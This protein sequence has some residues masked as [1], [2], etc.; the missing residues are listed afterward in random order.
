MRSTFF[1]GIAAL[2]ALALPASAQVFSIGTNPSGSSAYAGGSAI[3]KVVSDNSDLPVRVAPQGGPVVTVPLLNAGELEFSMALSVVVKLAQTG[4]QMF[5]NAG[6]QENVRV[7]A[8]L[9]PSPIGFMTRRE[10]GIASLDDLKGKRVGW[11]Y[12]KQ[13]IVQVLGDAYLAAAGITEDMVEPVAEPNAMSG[14]QDLVSGRIDATV[15]TVLSGGAQ[16][17]HTQTGGLRWLPLPQDPAARE[18]ALRAAPGTVVMELAAGQASG[19]DEA[20]ELLSTPLVLLTNKDVPDEVVY[21]IARILH[22]HKD[23]LVK[24]YGAL[25]AFDPAEIAVDFGVPY[26]PGAEAYYREAGVWQGD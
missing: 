17:A 25:A 4:E 10:D 7:V 20:I 5:Q 24:S 23:A 19:V 16:Q 26:H 1:A 9:M 22:S 12:P 21:E 8:A 11:G 13:K 3:A 2:A 14:I 18:A 15:M 6:P